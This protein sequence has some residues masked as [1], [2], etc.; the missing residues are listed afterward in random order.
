MTFGDF[1]LRLTNFDSFKHGFEIGSF[2]VTKTS[3]PAWTT[4]S[5]VLKSNGSGYE[6][7][8]HISVPDATLTSAVVTGFGANTVPDGGTTVLLLSLALGVVGIVSRRLK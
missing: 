4:A 2:I 3:G 1:N 6:A 8:A 5:D 7:A